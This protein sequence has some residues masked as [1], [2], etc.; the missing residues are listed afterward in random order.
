MSVTQAVHKYFEVE[1]VQD[2]PLT[3]KEASDGK[4]E[5]RR[6]LDFGNGSRG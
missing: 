2:G 5:V 4:S 3:W 1:V 6:G